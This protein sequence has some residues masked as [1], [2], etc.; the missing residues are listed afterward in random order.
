MLASKFLEKSYLTK[1]SDIQEVLN[2]YTVELT[3]EDLEQLTALSVP[4][5]DTTVERHQ[6]TS[7]ILNMDDLVNHLRST[8]LS[9][10]WKLYSNTHGDVK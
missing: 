4:E 3:K 2:S 6:L 1:K 7:T 5:E 9:M 8:N 10:T